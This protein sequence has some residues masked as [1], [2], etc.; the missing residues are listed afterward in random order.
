ML[1]SYKGILKFLLLFLCVPA[2][3]D[4]TQSSVNGLHGGHCN[5]TYRNVQ[6]K[7]EVYVCKKTGGKVPTVFS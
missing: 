7:I 4:G 5:D 1:L 6:M 2:T 3:S